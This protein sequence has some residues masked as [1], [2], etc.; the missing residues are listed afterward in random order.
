MFAW[1]RYRYKLS[2]LQRNGQNVR[3]QY[4]KEMRISREQ[5]KSEEEIAELIHTH[6]NKLQNSHI[7]TVVLEI[8]YLVSLAYKHLVPVPTVDANHFIPN[9]KWR[10]SNRHD[11]YYLTPMAI[12][13]LRSAVR[14]E[15][16]ERSE[17]ARSWLPAITGLIAAVIA[18]LAV[19]LGR[20]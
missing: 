6:S 5:N 9:T 8:N 3:L 19:I 7:D 15:R 11:E 20:R 13:E 4:D 14:A 10:W 1:L 2:R 16:K 18:L 12:Q 17:L